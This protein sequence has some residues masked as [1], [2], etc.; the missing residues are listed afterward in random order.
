MT[1]GQLFKNHFPL[2]LCHSALFVLLLAGCSKEGDH[3]KTVTLTGSS[4][5]APLV[6]DAAKRYEETHPEVRIEVQTGGSSRGIADALSGLADFGMVSR[7]LKPE[8][9]ALQ[10]HRIAIDGVCLIVH[11]D[12]SV[13]ALNRQQ[14]IDIY[15]GKIENWS[16]VGGPEAEIVVASKAEGRATLEVFLGYTRLDSADIKADVVVGENQQAIKTVAGNPQAIGYVSIGAAA[17]EAASGT[18]IKLLACDGVAPTSEAVAKGLFP[19]TRP[20]QLVSK[21]VPSPA[22]QAFLAFLTSSKITDL[23]E[24]HLYVPVAR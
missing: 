23:I 20:L 24:A 22:A 10:A 6:A 8:E 4:T 12:N 7:N 18:P 5:V 9:S 19:I 13:P 15:T 21:G 1:A 17:S 3:T 2:R 16:A 14:I 11:K